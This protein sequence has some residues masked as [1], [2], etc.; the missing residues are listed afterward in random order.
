M[1]CAGGVAAARPADRQAGGGAIPT[2]AL[3]HLRVIVIP[4]LAAKKLLE[5]GHYLGSVAGGTCLAFGVLAQGRLLGAI[6]LGV[7]PYNAHSL[8]EGARRGDCLTLTRLWLSDHLPKNSESRV[9]GIVT[10]ALRRHTGL[11]FL[12]AYADPARGHRGAVYQG[13]GW[14]YTGQ[15]VP[16]ALYDIG[17]GVARHSRSLAHCFGTH[18]VRYLRGRGASVRVIPQLPKHR[19]ACFLDRSWLVRLRVP[20]LPYPKVEDV[21]RQVGGERNGLSLQQ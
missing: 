16:M 11:K 21:I 12:I 18:S 20:V 3:R 15:S 19:Y 17:D 10:R 1:T 9:L 13:A 7:G 14:V 2:S 6:T 5:P 4:L 8:V